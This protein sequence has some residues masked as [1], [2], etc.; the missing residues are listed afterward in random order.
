VLLPDQATP[1]ATAPFMTEHGSGNTYRIASSL[2]IRLEGRGLALSWQDRPTGAKL[3]GTAGPD[4][5]LGLKIVSERLSIRKLANEHREPVSR[6]Y[7]LLSYL[8][9]Q[10]ILEAPTSLLRRDPELFGSALTD[11]RL[12][13]TVF[14]L[15]WHITNACDMNC[16]HCYDRSRRSRMTESQA[17][18]VLDELDRFR[19]RHWVAASIDFTGG[20]PF[21]YPG[22]LELYAEAVRR[23][24]DVAILGNPVRR[25]QIEALCWV[26]PPEIYQVSLEGMRAHNDWVRGIGNYD[27]V[28]A[29]LALLEEIGVPSCVMLTATNAN[30]REIL[31]LA[32]LLEGKTGG[33]GF[34]RLACVGSGASLEQPGPVHYR[35]FLKRY[36][37]Y[38]AESKTL[39]FKDNLINLRLWETGCALSEGCT[40]FGCGAAFNSLSVL[41]DGEAH[42]CRRF[43]SLLGNIQEQTL[44]EL[45]HSAA[46]ERYRRGMRACKGCPI[47]HACGG[48]MSTVLPQTE[49]ISEARDRFCWRLN[50]G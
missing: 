16:R 28:I 12:T 29:F 19:R 2:K 50:S 31:P 7:R 18:R 47:R 15:Q 13:V 5:L 41:P 37:A 48:C 11:D 39:V 14:C 30:L 22:L 32:R 8:D 49:N 21:L 42:A 46:A 43:P 44:D 26:K 24:F 40:G 23:G 9:R 33:F 20:N 1:V 10:G 27:R 45:Y 25:D 17:I 36:I 4:E 35:N 3:S 34:G 6:F 38:A